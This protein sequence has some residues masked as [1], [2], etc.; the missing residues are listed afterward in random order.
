MTAGCADAGA[1]QADGAASGEA[2]DAPEC[3]LGGEAAQA[4][5]TGSG[6]AQQLKPAQRRQ[7]GASKRRRADLLT[8]QEQAQAQPPP[9]APR[10][11]IDDGWAKPCGGAALRP[12]KHRNVNKPC[13]RGGIL[14]RCGAREGYVPRSMRGVTVRVCYSRILQARPRCTRRRRGAT[15]PPLPHMSLRTWQAHRVGAVQLLL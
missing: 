12:R 13:S 15:R 8:G 7:G 1:G 9:P 2:L 14:S 5:G 6:V 10:P 4:A 11:G 3:R